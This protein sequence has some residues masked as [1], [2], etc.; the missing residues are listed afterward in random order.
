MRYAKHLLAAALV[1]G[2]AGGSRGQDVPA[3]KSSVVPFKLLPS[4]HMLIEL[5]I[6]GKGPFRVIFDT[7]APLN[8]VNTKLAKAAG[9]LKKGESG[10]S[11]FGGMNTI[12]VDKVKLGGVSIDK[13]PVVVMDHPTVKSISDAFAK[14]Y[15]TIDGIVGF[16]LFARFATTV[17][18][19]KKELTLTPT[20]YKPGDYLKDLT[21]TLATAGDRVGAKVVGAVGVWGFQV[22]QSD[23]DEAGTVV[24]AVAAGG[25]AAKAGLKAGDRL[26]TLDGRWTDTIGDTYLAASLVQP[27]RSAAVVL[28][29]GGKK[30]TLTCTPSKGY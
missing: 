14:D 4:R 19:Q 3:A 11:I 12:E 15:G 9:I 24:K 28:E 20:N 16:P 2:L 21:Q 23:D 6:N 25:P 8:L 13:L 29:R 1:A 5:T 18:Y 27:G 22:E 7:G 30:V 17:D 10:F 26:L